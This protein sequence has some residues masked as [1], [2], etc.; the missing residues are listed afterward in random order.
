MKICGV[1]KVKG[2]GTVVTV[3]ATDVPVGGLK[4]GILVW[5]GEAAWKIVGIEHASF[6]SPKAVGLVLRGELRLRVG[7]YQLLAA[8]LGLGAAK[9]A[10]H[11]TFICDE[12]KFLEFANRKESHEG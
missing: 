5:Q 8:A 1:Y 9:T 3:D 2:R 12:K 4:I 10:G 11:L 6:N 7:E